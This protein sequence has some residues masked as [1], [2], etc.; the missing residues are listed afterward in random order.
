[1][2]GLMSITGE[3]PGRPPV[4]C[5][6]PVSDITAGILAAMGV[7]AA[8]VR[9]L[10][11]GKGQRVDT[12]LFEAA[13]VHT[14][15]QSAIC[16]ATG[17]APG[18]MGSG[19]PLNAPYQAFETADG[20][21]TV[22]AANQANWLK[23]LQAIEAPELEDDPRFATN[24]GRMA[25]LAEL[26]GALDATFRRK[27]SADWLARFEAAGLPAGPVLDVGEM[28]R[29]PQALARAMVTQAPHSRLP[30]DKASRERGNSTYFSDRAVP[31]LPERLSNDLCCLRPEED[32]AASVAS[33]QLDRNGNKLSH[34]FERAMIRSHARLTYQ[35]AEA[36]KDGR[37]ALPEAVEGCIAPLY[38]AWQALMRA[39]DKREPLD[40]ELQ[41][42][43]VIL[44]E[45]GHVDSV[46]PRERL[47]SHR[48]IEEFMIIA[49]VAA[50][51]ELEQR[52]TPCMYRIHESPTPEKLRALKDF[53]RTFGI[54]FTLGEVVRPTLFNRVLNK[55][56]NTEKSDVVNQAI[57]R[58]QAQ[59]LYSPDN[60][61]HFGLALN[62]YAHFTSPI[63]RY[64]DLLVHR[65]LIRGLGL[66]PGGLADEE[67]EQF[68]ALGEHISMT[69]RRSMAAEREA[70]D[71]YLAAY[72]SDHIEAEFSGTISGAT[73]AGLF[74]RL[75][76][77]GADGLVPISSIGA[78]YFHVDEEARALIGER[79]GRRHRLGDRVRVRLLQAD[80][81]TGSLS[82]RLTDWTEDDTQTSAPKKR[83]SGGRKR[84]GRQPRQ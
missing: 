84:Q 32:R 56:R 31:M 6:A 66:G 53:L 35:A 59:A 63:R 9:R 12:S 26:V 48:L 75:D 37:Q 68:E 71:R 8:Y 80:P 22:G 83:K 72:H 13:I 77:T 40:L 27:T 79:S 11:T 60:V 14:Y 61:G 76:E 25:N 47:D 69:E 73:R 44:G 78:E 33:I 3:A 64:S 10:E 82:L 46:R 1:M 49:N 16:F 45:D 43:A 39:R 38:G 29:D 55:V 74:V 7:L 70:Q 30:L 58:A 36:A 52:R 54:N 15:W 65:A 18:P 51:E 62:R 2:S 57:L 41:E 34:K 17:E 42:L 20:W 67:L 4:K 50:A 81:V 21:I 19:H 28:H 23:M 5:G 24:D